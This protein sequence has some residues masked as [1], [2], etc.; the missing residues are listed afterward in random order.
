M[1]HAAPW[2]AGLVILASCSSS[3]STGGPSPSTGTQ[4]VWVVPASLDDLADLTY[5]DHP[6]PS[7]LRRNADGSIHCNGFYNPH[8]TIILQQYIDIACG[9]A[10]DAGSAAT[11]GLFDGFSPSA[12]GYV[13][14]TGDIDTTTLPADPMHA[15]TASSSVQLM[16]VDPKSPEHG[17]RKLVETF[18]WPQPDGV[19]WV[20]DTL[21]VQ[22][23]LGYPLR[24]KTRT[25][26]S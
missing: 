15:A 13:R 1:K 2:L 18:F 5:Y 22:P 26:S 20:H 17:Q 24:P 8:L 11:P 19:Y 9:T 14:F 4:A 3:K 7:N 12:A 10:A 6:W 21:A 16:D 25:P 23:A